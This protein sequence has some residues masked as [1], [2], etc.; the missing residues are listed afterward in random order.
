MLT[1]H[2]L[3]YR[4]RSMAAIGYRMAAK[5]RTSAPGAASQPQTGSAM[6]SNQFRT[7]GK[8]DP[9]QEWLPKIARRQHPRPRPQS[10]QQLCS[11]ARPAN[12]SEV[13]SQAGGQGTGAIPLPPDLGIPSEGLLVVNGLPVRTADPD[14]QPPR[15][16]DELG[17][18]VRRCPDGSRALNA[19]QNAVTKRGLR[20]E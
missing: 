8:K 17:N 4:I 11:R 19:S 2:G 20:A 9:P 14:S 6:C 15:E 1:P 10:P 7:R 13:G 18:E 12:W 16:Q 3:R 5:E